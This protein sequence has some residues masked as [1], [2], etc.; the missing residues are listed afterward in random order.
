MELAEN[1]DDEAGTSQSD[2]VE[3][4][5]NDDPFEYLVPGYETFEK[6]TQEAFN[7]MRNG[8]KAANN[9]PAGDNFNYYACFP[10]FNDARNK[11]IKLM[12]DTMRTIMGRSIGS[13]NIA[14]RDIDEKFELLLDANDQLLDQANILMDE[15][16]GIKQN[17]QVELV[18]SQ[19]PKT[20]VNGSWNAKT[21]ETRQNPNSEKI[22]LLGG[23]NVQRPQL[24][25]KD[26]IDNSS[27]PWVP[28][29][30]EKPNSLKPLA[31]YVEETEHGEVFNH[32]YEFE[33]DKFEV[34]ECQ[35]KKSVPVKYKSLDNTKFEYIETPCEFKTLLE[36]LKNYKEIAIDLEHHSYRT[37]QGITCLMQISTEHTDYLIDTLTLRS[38]LHQLNEIFTKPTILKV[39]H[40]AD[41]DILWLQRDLSLYIVNMFDTHQAAVQL[42]L[43]YRS[44]NKLLKRY[45]DIDLNKHFQLAD[46]RIRPLTIEMMKYAREDTHY[47]LYIKDMLK[48]E[49]IDAANGKTNLLKVVFDKSTDI[50]KRTY[51]KPVWSEESCMNMYRKEPRAFNNKQMYAFMELHKWRDLVAREEDDSVDYVLP[52]QML[53]NISD[54]LPREMQGILA[55][56]NLIPP[57]VRQNLLKIHKI[58]LKAREQ[59][60]VKSIPEADIRQRS[61]QQNHVVDFGNSLFKLHDI[62]S[63][64]E[65]RADL[66]CLLDKNGVMQPSKANKHQAVKHTVTV[67]DSPVMSENEESKDSSGKKAIFVSPFMRYKRVIPMVADQ[68]AKEREK[69]LK[70]EVEEQRLNEGVKSDIA[71]AHENQERDNSEFSTPRPSLDTRIVHM[72]KKAKQDIQQAIEERKVQQSLVQ[73]QDGDDPEVKSIRVRKKG[74]KK[75]NEKVLRQQGMLP[76]EKFDYKSVDFNSF[77]GGSVEKTANQAL[78]QKPKVKLMC[79]CVTMVSMSILV[80]AV[81]WQFSIKEC[82]CLRHLDV[83]NI[84][85]HRHA[86]NRTIHAAKAVPLFNETTLANFTFALPTRTRNLRVFL[87]SSAN[88]EETQVDCFGLGKG[89]ATVLERIF[90]NNPNGSNALD[91]RFSLSSRK[92]PHRV[93]VVLGEQ[94]GLEWTDFKIERRTVIIVHGFLS[95]GQETWISNL[96][97][98]LLE[99]DDVN[100]VVVD[101]S[102]GSNTWN[103]YKAAVNTRIVGYQISKFIEH[104]TNA[105]ISS[106]EPN[107]SNWGPL[108]L[109]GHSLGAHICGFAA[110]ELKKI[111]NRW[112]VQ[113]ITGLDPAQP[114]FK[115]AEASAHLHKTDAP[116]VDVI[117][118]NGRL[119]R[120]LGLGLP[121][122][123]GH[124]DFYPNGGEMQPGCV[125][126]ESSIFDNI[127]PKKAIQEAICSHGRSYIYLTES[128]TSAA[129]RNCSFWAR[130]WDLTY[131]HFLQIIR[132]PCS[133]DSCTEMGIRAE[134]YAQRGKF[135]VITANSHPFCA[136]S[137]DVVEEVKR[138]LEEHFSSQIED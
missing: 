32:P 41:M 110:K 29:L 1:W 114:C 117:H 127:I 74:E 126:T 138:Q 53:F 4:E 75:A 65:P 112:T 70:K 128:L 69:E 56:C 33:L 87:N 134:I 94:F 122:A 15:E 118:T 137:S 3:K 130:N 84:Q 107:V 60:L 35:L 31:L 30:K 27:K 124:I 6:Y 34:P 19:M 90:R 93:Q 38:E 20:A 68:E 9:L 51:V 50:C 66:P 71:K 14:I 43:P 12:L 109:I 58:V 44:L 100:V 115:R 26:K 67:F 81:L 47:L 86:L 7:V 133:E 106:E 131:R 62:P 36:D 95:H 91:V 49:L 101:W 92:Q 61:M 28:R 45:C 22:R 55:C 76:A 116:F 83:T 103:Y 121:D 96:E 17:P 25:F 78:F 135:F 8:I 80:L 85:A 39:F 108:H 54:T 132:E 129:T 104:I 24:M 16:C 40:G 98:A 59:P 99:W 42:N 10:S 102:A 23:K 111:R 123:I 63:G 77:Q 13:M 105:T 64:T 89:V 11:S 79:I 37:F 5:Q 82:S 120:R 48:N 119:L 136:N 113:R 2:N 18:V 88:E 125:R 46:W 57:L 72:S 97:E 52:K 73:I 21:N